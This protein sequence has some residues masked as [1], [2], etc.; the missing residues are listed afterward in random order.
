M[1]DFVGLISVARARARGGLSRGACKLG[2]LAT[3]TPPLASRLAFLRGERD[4]SCP[5]PPR[6][7]ARCL[8]RA[9]IKQRKTRLATLDRLA[10]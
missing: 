2:S 5:T 9:S 4:G 7:I 10:F 3:L 1:M 6:V 8:Q